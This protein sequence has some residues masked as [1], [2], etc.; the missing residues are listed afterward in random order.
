MAISG[1]SATKILA[2]EILLSITIATLQQRRSLRT[3]RSPRFT[4]SQMKIIFRD[5][6]FAFVFEGLFAIL[7]IIGINKVETATSFKSCCHH[8]VKEARKDIF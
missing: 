8:I 4:Q 7:P 3:R 5:W 6:S 1:S 2:S